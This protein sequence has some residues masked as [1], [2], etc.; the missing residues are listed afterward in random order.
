M[1]AEPPFTAYAFAIEL[2]LPGGGEPLCEA[3]F[4]QCDG[5]VLERSII[6]LREGGAAGS[7]R[8]L[9]GQES[10]GRVTLRRGMTSDLA[11]WDWWERVRR[12]P[13][14]RATC[15]V[16][17]LSPDLAQERVR[18]R[19]HGCLPAKIAAPDLNAAGNEVAI[20]T[21]EIACESVELVRP[22]RPPAKDV[23]EPPL[24]AELR[25]LDAGFARE[26]NKARRVTAQ[27]NPADLRTICTHEHGPRTELHVRL[28]FDVR[29]AD[30]KRRRA[31]DDVR[32]LTERVAYFATPRADRGGEAARPA[33]RLVWG[34]FAF[35]GRVESLEESIDEFSPDGRP[36]RATVA[37]VLARDEIG[38]YAFGEP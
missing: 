3:A 36:Q 16:V 4:C 10:F 32:R 35:D 5:L 6:T 1:S 8:L 37:L 22:G 25:E 11:L 21:L 34:T 28:V 30:S 2:R 23:S 38:P 9:A 12:D 31:P 24:K 14:V 17:V 15:D 13:R 7:V 27:I 33:V 20:E 26:I 19:L 18:F 29:L